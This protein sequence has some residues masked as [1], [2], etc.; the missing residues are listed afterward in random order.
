MSKN[1]IRSVWLTVDGGRA[2]RL[3]HPHRMA[4]FKRNKTE[5]YKHLVEQDGFKVMKTFR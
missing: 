2:I 5:V 3:L 1:K 4:Q